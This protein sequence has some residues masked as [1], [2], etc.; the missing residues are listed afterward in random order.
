M[1]VF[2]KGAMILL[3]L[4]A[5]AVAAWAETETA[6]VAGGCFWCVESDFE[7]VKGV[8][9]V[10]SGYSGGDGQN[11][12]YEDHT[13]H[14]EVVKITFDPSVIS[15][16]DLMFK[17][18]RSIDVTDEDGQFCDR[19]PAYQSAIFV[20]DA[21]QKKIAEQSVALAEA[22]LGRAIVTPVL[23][24]KTF[25][26]AESYHQD[27]HKSSDIVL[28]RAGPKKKKNA[29]KFYRQACGRDAQVRAIWGDRAFLP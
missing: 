11:P 17:F 8:V 16:Q 1:N 27:Y 18:L 29:Y 19:G 7:K 15:Y 4:F 2:A 21:A 12:T 28:T 23:T 20:S 26:P 3:S 25:W 10:V 9:D 6:V 14:R 22:D 5:P 24:A 13:G